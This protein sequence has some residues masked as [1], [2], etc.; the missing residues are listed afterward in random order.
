MK[1][2]DLFAGVGG[3]SLGFSQAGF[4]IV[5]ANEYNKSIAE[6]FKKNHKDT[7]VDSTDIRDIDFEKVFRPFENKISVVMGGPPCQGFSQKG[8]R[9][10]IS[11][12]RN[13]MFQQFVKVVEIVKPEFFVLENVPN[14]LSTENG[15]FKQEIIDI[16]TKLGYEVKA[17]VLK[18]ENFGVP[19]TRRRAVFLGRKGKLNFDLPDGNGK[20][21][22]VSEALDDLPVLKSGEGK[23][24]QLY[25]TVPLNFF[26]KQMR[27]KSSVLK[28]HI[29]TKHSKIALERLS[30]ISLNGSK[31]D[32][33]AHHR[34][35]S[36]H[37]GTWTR[38]K[39]NGFARTITTR[40]DTPSSGQ[41][42]LPFQDRCITVRE[43]A[44]LQSFPDDFVFH[45][46]KTNQMLQVGNAVP[47]M[48]AYEIAKTIK[49]NY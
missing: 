28:N 48:M 41:F 32:L 12:E 11:D 9:A 16:F 17:K 1:V 34:T 18:T 2:I 4:S 26:Q 8:K 20:K 40:F 15:Y 45:G 22:T 38:L 43:A 39:P 30:L 10:G 19:Q 25:T 24:D 36:I 29:A 14:I 37:S 42:T 23:E 31:E 7:M 21:T 3:L 44:R 33:P 6:S 49:E 5:Y 35:K 13:F 46:T 47:P 27:H